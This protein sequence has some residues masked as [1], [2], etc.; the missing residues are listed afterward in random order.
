[1]RSAAAPAA[2]AGATHATGAQPPLSFAD[3]ANLLLVGTTAAELLHVSRAQPG[4]TAL[5]HGAAGA[6][7]NSVLQH[8]RHL[9]VRVVGT[10]SKANFAFVRQFGGTPVEYGTG[11][12]ERIRAAA[13]EGISAALDTVGSDEATAVSLALVPDR[14]RVITIAAAPRAKDD[15]YFFVGASNPQKRTV[16]CPRSLSHP[17]ACRQGVLTV[18]IAQTFKFEDAPAAFAMLTGQHRPGKI[19]LI[20]EN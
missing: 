2:S 10:A 14:R 9:G 18:P 3:A 15:R 16:P 1:M 12:L 19:A 8:V 6:V 17:R 5:L 20:N 13:P 4:E 7:G 11:L